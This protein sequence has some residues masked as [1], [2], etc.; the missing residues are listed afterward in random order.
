MNI[1]KH[2]LSH[3]PLIRSVHEP[4][5]RTTV[6]DVL[7]ICSCRV[8]KKTQPHTH[9]QVHRDTHRQCVV[10][11][12][13]GVASL[14]MAGAAHT[15]PVVIQYVLYNSREQQAPSWCMER[16]HTHIQSFTR[17]YRR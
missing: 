3:L 11:G 4:R 12:T 1:E 10:S 13:A 5:N 7:S 6:D 16:Q 17:K 9:T 8:D 2:A 14:Q 15:L